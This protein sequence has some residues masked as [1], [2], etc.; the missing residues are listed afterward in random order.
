MSSN[1]SINDITNKINITIVDEIQPSIGIS[2]VNPTSNNNASQN[3]FFEFTTGVCCFGNDCG[4]ISVSFDPK[5]ESEYTYTSKKICKNRKCSLTL[6]ANTRFGYEDNQWK[7]IENLKSFEDT[8]D[9]N[10]IVQKDTKTDPDVICADWNYTAITLKNVSLNRVGEMPLKIYRLMPEVNKNGLTQYEKIEIEEETQSIEFIDALDKKELVISYAY[11]DEIH[12]GHNSTIIYLNVSA[13]NHDA[14]QTSATVDIDC[15]GLPLGYGTWA[16]Q[17]AGII[18]ENITIP[19]GSAIESSHLRCSQSG[20]SFPMPVDNI[21][22]IQIYGEDSD[23]VNPFYEVNNNISN[24]ARTSANRSKNVSSLNSWGTTFT[25]EVT[26]IIQEIIHRGGWSSGNALTL[27]LE[28]TDYDGIYFL[29]YDSGESIQYLPKLN[30]TYSE[31]T[32]KSG[33]VSTTP[34]TIPFYTNSSNPLIIN[35]NQNQCQNVTWWVNTTGTLDTTHTF[36]AFA[37]KTS[38]MGIN[39]ITNKINITII[40]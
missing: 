13:S 33:L 40:S 5:K 37:N 30:I 31:A 24:R 39:N 3:D 20:S 17:H 32:A 9:I 2:L 14:K 1:T 21:T 8:T 23:D 27:L 12:L 26:N 11:G 25:S 19:Q 36:F 35:L 29:S 16:T 4:N 10:C 22:E 38:D 6:Y 15:Y 7:P 28:S 34:G 18:F